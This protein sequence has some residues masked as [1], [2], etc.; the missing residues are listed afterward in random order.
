MK[1]ILI[2]S[3]SLFFA[4]TSCEN[5]K[6]VDT[7][8]TNQEKE[9]TIS[10][11]N[12]GHELVYKMTQKVGDY[13]KLSN[14]K[15]VVYTY[16]YQTPDGKSDISTEKYIFNGE[17]SYG[18]YNK[19]QRTL[20]N[21]EGIIEQGYDGSEFWLKN[22]GKLINDAKALKRVAFN[23]PT[24]YYWF[25]M[26][27]KLLDPGL[28]Y[29]YLGEKTINNLNYDIVK[30]TFESKENTPKDIYQL[31]INKETNLVDQF[32]FTV[33]DFKKAEPLLMELA[34][35]NIDGLL[36][37]TKRRYKNS[38]WNADVTDKPWILVNWTDIKFD[39]NLNKELFRK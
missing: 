18:K 28:N 21:L 1:H 33:M 6:K 36:I 23:R 35:E 19:H 16:T 11:Q 38:N 9:N 31:Y 39:N 12:K 3:L 7:P 14:K 29:E 32:L 8:S 17:L 24:N 13:S 10:F 30:V 25:T 27:Q 37:P 34:Y 5:E 2:L 15:D 26:M 20:A 22:N 4:L